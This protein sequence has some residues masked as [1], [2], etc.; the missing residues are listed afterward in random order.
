MS[1]EKKNSI[2]TIIFDLDGT[3]IDTEAT[4][5]NAIVEIFRGWGVNLTLDD[6]SKVTGRTWDVT[7][8]YLFSKYSVP[9]PIDAAKKTVLKRYREAVESNLVT[10]PG[11]AEAIR[12]FA[13]HFT[14]GLVSGSTRR[15]IL[16]ALNQMGVESLFR[17]VLGAEDYPRSKPAPD[18]Y[19]KAM[20]MLAVEPSACLIF[21]DSTPGITSARE[22]GAWVVAIMVANSFN[23]DQSLAHEKIRD[24]SGINAEW[25]KNLTLK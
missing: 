6:A 8:D 10:I 24:F 21:E 3:L 13:Q 15:D 1:S 23:H 4:A 5:A 12:D 17:V 14:L 19:L 22:A 7:F 25:V 20:N 11:G 18:G 9:I 2:E 16:W